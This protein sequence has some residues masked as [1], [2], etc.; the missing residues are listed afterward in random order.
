MYKKTDK[1]YKRH[2]LERS[3]QT[4]LI[5]QQLTIVSK[6]NKGVLPRHT[7]KELGDS[8]GITRERVRQIAKRAGFNTPNGEESKKARRIR[9]CVACGVEYDG[10]AV[11]SKYH[12]I[13]CKNAYYKDKYWTTITCEQCKKVFIR[14]K[15]TA[16]R[17]KI[18]FCCKRCNGI[19]VGERYGWGSSDNRKN[20]KYPDTKKELF[21]TLG[22]TFTVRRFGSSFGYLSYGGAY[23]AVR[24]L[25]MRNMIKRIGRKEWRV[26]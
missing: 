5:E 6:I 21:D 8:F 22:P 16:G 4:K 13:E 12:S 19:Y 24:S 20:R 26:A 2:I 3:S 10:E 9:V 25:S 17:S 15:A 11:R 1:W 18:H 23:R 7:L 14:T